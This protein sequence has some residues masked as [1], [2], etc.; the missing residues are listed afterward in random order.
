MTTTT[1]TT[2]DITSFIENIAQINLE[3][4]GIAVTILVFFGGAFYLFNFRPLKDTIEKQEDTLVALKKEVEENL[5]SSK[6]EIKRDLKDF[7]KSNTKEISTL[8]QRKN[9]KLA[10][11]IKTKIATFEKDFTEKFNTFAEEKDQNL[12]TVILSEFGNQ[13][14]TLEKS[15]NIE[16]NN[17]NGELEKKIVPLQDKLLL[18]ESSVVKIRED[19]FDL[20][21]EHHLGKKQ[22]GIN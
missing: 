13:L 8:V 12:K 21:I 22:I 5:L 10:S 15:L 16:I 17:K 2:A 4:L 18:L 7:E 11:D 19:L 1:L 20:Q 9:E 3:Y 14:H 6:N